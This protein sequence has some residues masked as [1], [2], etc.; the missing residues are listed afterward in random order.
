M[1]GT[2]LDMTGH[3]RMKLANSVVRVCVG[4]LANIILIPLWGITGAAMAALIHEVVANGL[5]MVEVWFLYRILPYS[6]AFL[7]PLAAGLA[8]AA[9]TLLVRVWMPVSD[10][11]ISIIL[12]ILV[13]LGVYA[14]AIQILGLSLEER[15]MVNKLRRRV[16]SLLP[17]HS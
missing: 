8:A 16:T 10:Q 17:R 1:C 13:M 4:I 9:V 3:T 7:K 15:Q 6:W 14:L 5:P 11:L 2:I 12:Q